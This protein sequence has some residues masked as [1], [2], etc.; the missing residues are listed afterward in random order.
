MNSSAKTVTG[1]SVAKNHDGFISSMLLS[2]GYYHYSNEKIKFCCSSYI[3]PG[4]LAQKT[5]LLHFFV[6]CHGETHLLVNVT[7]RNSLC[8]YQTTLTFFPESKVKTPRG[9]YLLSIDKQDRRQQFASALVI[10]G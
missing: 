6:T 2:L 3:L 4:H 9:V 1:S 5:K 8:I 7:R 10:N